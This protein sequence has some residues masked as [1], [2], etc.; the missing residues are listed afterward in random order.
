M[1]AQVNMW[2]QDLRGVKCK[3]YIEIET[4]KENMRRVKNQEWKERGSLFGFFRKTKETCESFNKI[5]NKRID[6]PMFM[7]GCFLMYSFPVL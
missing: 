3:S 7:V 2:W 6:P 4:H 1:R 5:D